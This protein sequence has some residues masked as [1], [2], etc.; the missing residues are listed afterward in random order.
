MKAIII[1]AGMGSRL[2]PLTNDKPKCML[3]LNGKTLLQHQIR[4]LRE[5]GI[6]RVALVKGYKKE[7]I[8]YPDLV[9]YFND[10]YQNN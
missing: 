7:A 5:A 1:A 3:E 10:N 9:Y 4:A 2:N 8:G 6:D